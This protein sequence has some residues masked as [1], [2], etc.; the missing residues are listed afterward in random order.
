MHNVCL[1][2]PDKKVTVGFINELVKEVFKDIDDEKSWADTV[3]E[4]IQFGKNVIRGYVLNETLRQPP[5]PYRR[6]DMVSE[7][8]LY[9]LCHIQDTIILKTALFYFLRTRTGREYFEKGMNSLS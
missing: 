1:Y 6:N 4:V 8:R 2:P 5:R 3:S 7:N 9:E